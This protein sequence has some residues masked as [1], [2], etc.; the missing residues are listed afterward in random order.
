MNY[1]YLVVP[2]ISSAIGWITNYIAIKM[3]F[4]PREKKNILGVQWQGIIPRRKSMLAKKL[5]EVT[6]RD[7]LSIDKISNHLN[8]E[9]SK[10]RISVLLESRFEYILKEKIIPSNSLFKMIPSSYI[11]SIVK[12]VKESLHEET[13]TINQEI[14]KTI[15]NIDI[16]RMVTEEVNN[17]SN[18]RLED[19]LMSVL[20]KELKW[21]ELLGAILG[22]IIGV[23]QIILILQF[24]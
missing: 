11:E 20:R 9:E 3:L 6:K 18:E 10:Q 5:G 14:I 13:E 22:F 12:K 23:I 17:L 4:R 16:E 19:M 2:L 7:L 15:K 1:I 8:T 24:N 21:I